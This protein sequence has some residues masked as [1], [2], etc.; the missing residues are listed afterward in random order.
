MEEKNNNNN[1]GKIERLAQMYES[2]AASDNQKRSAIPKKSVHKLNLNILKEFEDLSENE[3]S[4]TNSSFEKPSIKPYRKPYLDRTNDMSL[5][6]ITASN[7][8]GI[9]NEDTEDEEIQSQV[10]IYESVLEE[11]NNDVKNKRKLGS[12]E[13]PKSL[14]KVGLALGLLVLI[15]T[16]HYLFKYL[17]K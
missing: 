10:K 7:D 6:T 12:D 17:L 4:K 2:L 11:I 5:G 1:K 8:S 14:K 15:L 13:Q 9:L 16:L 3:S